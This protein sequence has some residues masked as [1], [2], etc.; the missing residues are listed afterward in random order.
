[1]PYLFQRQGIYPFNAGV[2]KTIE[3]KNGKYEIHLIIPENCNII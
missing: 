3:I 2:G 1:M